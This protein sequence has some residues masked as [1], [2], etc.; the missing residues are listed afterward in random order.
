M[1]HI[2]VT[3]PL[4]CAAARG[5]QLYAEHTGQGLHT[6]LDAPGG[7]RNSLPERRVSAAD[8]LIT[9]RESAEPLKTTTTP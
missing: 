2:T 5:R 8:V 6:L 4:P 1:K 3:G 7:I 9:V